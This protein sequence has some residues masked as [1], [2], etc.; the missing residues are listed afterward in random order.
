MI[1]IVRIKNIVVFVVDFFN[2]H[3][4]MESISNLQCLV[5][6]A[7]LY[8]NVITL[9]SLDEKVRVKFP[10]SINQFFSSPRV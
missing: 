9:S 5:L 6:N 2:Y 7:S 4:I 1:N 10:T 8:K 3:R